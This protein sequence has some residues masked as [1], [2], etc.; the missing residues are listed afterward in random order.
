MLIPA[1]AGRFFVRPAIFGT[2][3]TALLLNGVVAQAEFLFSLSSTATPQ[4]DGTFFYEYN[5]SVLPDSTIGASLLALSVLGTAAPTSLSGPSGWDASFSAQDGLIQFQSP[6]VSFDILPGASGLFSF[7]S[8][9]GPI[10]TPYTVIGFDDAGG[11]FVEGSGLIL[12][13]AVPEPGSLALLGIGAG[14]V[15][16]AAGRGRR[17][18]PSLAAAAPLLALA[19]LP[20]GAARASDHGDTRENVARIGSDMTDVFIFPSKEDPDSVV[21][22]TTVRPLI[23]PDQ[24]DS[25]F[26][27]PGLLIQFK[28]DTT[29][30]FVEDRVIQVRFE[31]YGAGQRVLV[32][33]PSRPLL[34]GTENLFGRRHRTVGHF[35][36]TF[37]PDP[38]SSMRVFCGVREDPFFFDVGRLIEIFPDR[39]IAI[40]GQPD[41]PN[42]QFPFG[43][44]VP[45]FLSWRPPGEAQDFLKDLSVLG[46][47]V[48]LPRAALGGGVIR[49]WCTVSV[50]ANPPR[51]RYVQQERLARP[52]INE[53]FATVSNNRHSANNKISPTQDINEVDKDVESFLTFPAGRSPAIRQA[54]RSVVIP[55]VMVADLSSNDQASYLGFET[56]GATGGR[57]GG[58]DLLDDVI[59]ISLGIVFGG[60]I[61]ALGLAPDDGAGIPALT[62]DNVDAGAKHFLNVFPYLGEPARP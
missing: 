4:A 51:F 46:V 61:P 30:D 36:Q 49:M 11:D 26:F 3:V 7:Y 56:G 55:D 9:V 20:A 57:F 50:P 39:G 52:V 17:R 35:N 42:A 60:T 23:T 14:A 27:D 15:I 22:A 40:F 32:S 62:S 12:G 43:P 41:L 34:V 1:R 28:I 24:V 53:F 44:N 31:G 54:I 18:R 29:G 10:R 13:P 58:R 21:L 19:L 25:V 2:V 59:D 16:V 5:L 33:G 38:R 8:P 48:E 47:V 45:Q 6:D 37:Q